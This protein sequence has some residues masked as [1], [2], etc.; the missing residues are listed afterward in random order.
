MTIDKVVSFAVE[1]GY[2]GAKFLRDWNG[3]KCYEPI[4]NDND[5]SFCGP[6]FIILVK[7]DEIRMST[8]EEAF[9]YLDSIIAE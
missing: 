5:I 1:N 8:P 6:L 2:E 4:V 9:L 7:D 3:Y